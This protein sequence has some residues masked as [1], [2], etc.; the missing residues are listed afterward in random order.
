MKTLTKF[1][2]INS[3]PTYRSMNYFLTHDFYEFPFKISP[4]YA[5]WEMYW[6]PSSSDLPVKAHARIVAAPTPDHL[7][8]L[9]GDKKIDLEME[10]FP[11]WETIDQCGRSNHLHPAQKQLSSKRNA[12]QIDTMTLAVPVPVRILCSGHYN[13]TCR[14]ALFSGH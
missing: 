5:C 10:G 7:I 11:P 13:E 8:T 6:K 1:Q 3:S 2:V 14:S 9:T 4:I 12:E